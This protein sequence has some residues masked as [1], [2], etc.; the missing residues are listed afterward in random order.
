ML[1]KNKI[2]ILFPKAYEDFS[3]ACKQAK[4]IFEEACIKLQGIARCAKL[5][6]NKE[7]ALINE[8]NLRR[9]PHFIIFYNFEGNNIYKKDISWRGREKI[10]M[11]TLI[12][13]VAD[14]FPIKC[15]II[16]TESDMDAFLND[17]QFNDKYYNKVKAIIFSDAK[18][19]YSPHILLE[20]LATNFGENI[21]FGYIHMMTDRPKKLQIAYNIAD[22]IGLN[23]D[24][25]E[26]PSMYILRSPLIHSELMEIAAKDKKENE[27]GLQLQTL[28]DIGIYHISLSSDVDSM[29]TFVEQYSLPLIPKIDGDNYLKECF[30]DNALENID[31]DKICYLFAI[32]NEDNN[33][34]TLKRI[35]LFGQYI[36]ASLQEVVQFG[37]L[38]CDQQN[39]FCQ[40][41]NLVPNNENNVRLV[42]IKS[43]QDYYRL[44][45]DGKDLILKSDPNGNKK[46]VEGVR[47]WISILE[48]TDDVIFGGD[49]QKEK[50]VC[51]DS[52]NC[53]NGDNLWKRGVLF[54]IKTPKWSDKID[55][56]LGGLGSMFGFVGSGVGYGFSAISTLLSSIFQV[57]F[58]IIIFVFLLPMLRMAR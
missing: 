32:S 8:F 1:I 40:S 22:K 12:D 55:N 46:L 2:P 50:E 20:Y 54:P 17:I 56:V 7:S 4:S 34:E 24:E 53:E 29:K 39:E 42:A 16:K 13:A 57:F 14:I 23:N 25:L 45:N 21:D 19:R 28:E 41:M 30:L 36:L 48:K 18:N 6:V 9:V 26:P 3:Q 15:K 35:F 37:W 27:N 38:N 31:E 33:H 47:D 11:Y 51:N 58:V 52:N 43:Y 10:K 44:Y 5:D 49:H